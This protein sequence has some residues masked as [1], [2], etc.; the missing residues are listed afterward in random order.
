MYNNGK[1][2]E[3]G[4]QFKGPNENDQQ[5][6]ATGIQYGSPTPLLWNQE[7]RN[8]D[9]F[10]IKSDVL[11]VL[12]QLNVPINNLLHEDIN[13]NWYHP[14]KSSL[15]RIGKSIIANYG[16]IHPL[17]LQ[18]YEIQKSVFGFEIY[19]DQIA[20]FNIN[21]SSTKKAYEDNSLQAIE[22]DFAFLFSKNIKGADIIQT[23]KKIDPQRIKKVIIFD[24]F[25]N[26]KLIENKK[27]IAFKVILQPIESTFTDKEIEKISKSIIKHI[28]TTFNGQLRQ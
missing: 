1:V 27:S 26:E 24:V 2:F 7:N 22:R 13:R 3:V 25:E 18:K 11:F 4:Q 16:E 6:M 20:Q 21:K 28:S 23:I 19:L 9:V 5:M 12:D 17:I 15:L 14:G 8:S 10:D